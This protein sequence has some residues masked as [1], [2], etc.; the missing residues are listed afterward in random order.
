MRV[1]NI[2]VGLIAFGL[3][4]STLAAPVTR[5]SG[6]FELKPEVAHAAPIKGQIKLNFEGNQIAQSEV[7]IDVPIYGKKAFP[8]TEIYYSE[9]QGAS[10]N[11]SVIFKLKGP[12][13]KWFYVLI[14]TSA[15]AGNSF[16]QVWYKA[17]DTLANIQA[18]IQA[19]STTIP[20][21]WAQIG[22]GEVTLTP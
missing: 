14:G 9:S 2:F 17:N 20:S 1:S 8:T 7:A 5:Y 10:L 3:S 6:T 15:D 19:G 12:S 11:N 16:T 13:H 4:L 18:V 22:A 21:N